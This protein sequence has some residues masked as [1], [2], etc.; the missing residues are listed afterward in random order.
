[1][2]RQFSLGRKRRESQQLRCRSPR[3]PRRVR[4]NKPRPAKRCEPFLEQLADEGS[5]SPSIGE[6]VEGRPLLAARI[7]GSR[8]E[9]VESLRVLIIANIHSG[10]CDGK[11]A[12]LALLRDVG[13]DAAHRWHAQPIELIVVPNYNADGNDRR[14]PGH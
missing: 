2:L 6:T 5:I 4:I 12:M 14:G 10:E 11:E 3:S 7:D 13:R 8:T 1:M 9:G